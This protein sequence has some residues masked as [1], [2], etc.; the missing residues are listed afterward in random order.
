ME[1]NELKNTWDAA[2]TPVRTIEEVRSMLKE[3]NHPVLKGVRRQMLME[4]AGWTLFLA[5]YYTMFDSNL[6]PL[7]VNIL[8]VVSVL[9]PFIHNLMS[10]RFSK[11]LVNGVT[12]K[13]SLIRYLARVK[14]YANVSLASR[15]L[16]MGGLLLFFLYGLK[17]DGWKYGLLGIILIV[18]LIQLF[19]LYRLWAARLKKLEKAAGGLTDEPDDRGTC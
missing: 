13:E 1:L 11:Y 4:L 19:V 16:F 5:G 2:A 10:Y 9:L 14:V 17:L 12:V 6:K 8:L 15:V 3:N 7:W 18:F